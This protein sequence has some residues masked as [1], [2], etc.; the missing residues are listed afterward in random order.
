MNELGCQPDKG[1]VLEGVQFKSG[2]AELEPGAMKKL[3][4]VAASLAG[5]E[6]VRVEVAGYTD[7]VG[8]PGRNQQLSVRRAQAV[9]DYLASR[10]VARDRLT[11]KG[12]GQENPIADNASAEGRSRNRRVELHPVR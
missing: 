2:T 8:D 6:Q 9:A 10:G 12:Y 4:Q 3:D 5:M 11:A 1:L 7:S